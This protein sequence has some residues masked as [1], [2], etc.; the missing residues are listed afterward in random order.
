MIQRE[1]YIFIQSLPWY[2]RKRMMKCT[3]PAKYHPEGNVYNHTVLVIDQ[4]L[5][6]GNVELANA[7]IYHDLGKL[8]TRHEEDG[9]VT[10]YGH[11]MYSLK[12][13]PDYMKQEISKTIEQHMRSHLYLNGKMSNPKKRIAFESD[14]NYKKYIKFSEYDDKGRDIGQHVIL[15]IGNSGSGKSRWI[16]TQNDYSIVCP[17]LIRKELTG[18]IS[19]QSKNKEVWEETYRRI[20]NEVK[21]GKNVILDSTMV[22]THARGIAVQFVEKLNVN[23][24]YKLF[25][26]DYKTAISRINGDISNG[27]DRSRVPDDIVKRQIS[28]LKE[29][30]F[31]MR[32][33]RFLYKD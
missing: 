29:S 2:L 17:D 1:S 25:Y 31:H 28:M 8:D 18:T 19:D 16:K 9:K 26:C 21:N 14:I 32:Y 4:A 12:Y 15:T 13:I 6:E 11:E 30:L 10:F 33:E 27:V 3:Q 22:N 20:E 5:K 24:M 23:V 7:A